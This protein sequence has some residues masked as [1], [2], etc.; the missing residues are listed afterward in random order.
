MW[1]VCV[2]WGGGVFSQENTPEGHTE[3]H[4]CSFVPY[5]QVSGRNGDHE[6]LRMTNAFILCDLV[7]KVQKR[8]AV[9]RE[10]SFKLRVNVRQFRIKTRWSITSVSFGLIY[11]FP[12]LH[13]IHENSAETLGHKYSIVNLLKNTK[14][15]SFLCQYPSLAQRSSIW[16]Y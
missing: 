16:N 1:F 2:I 9:N 8:H 11:H 6:C 5:K 12:D 4:K 14:I 3:T 13:H 10:R 7:W 15:W